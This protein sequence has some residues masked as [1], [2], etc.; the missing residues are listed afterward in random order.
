[1]TSWRNIEVTTKG[2]LHCNHRQTV[3][4]IRLHGKSVL[5]PRPRVSEW[6]GW[7]H[8]YLTPP[9]PPNPSPHPSSHYEHHWNMF[10][11]GSSHA[12][13]CI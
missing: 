11:T 5:L 1:M 8:K 7:E 12:P 2:M 9:F 3:L 4:E 10:K 6:D 13:P